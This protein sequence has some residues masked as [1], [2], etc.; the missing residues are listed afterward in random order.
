MS[1]VFEYEGLVDGAYVR[2]KWLRVITEADGVEHK[3]VL[4]FSNESERDTLTTEQVYS[5]LNNLVQYMKDV[6]QGASILGPE[7]KIP[8]DGWHFNGS[9]GEV[10]WAKDESFKWWDSVYY[11]NELDQDEPA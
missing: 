6:S 7:D 1:Y 5:H 4:N 11:K 8:S 2:P 9:W 10:E 3:I